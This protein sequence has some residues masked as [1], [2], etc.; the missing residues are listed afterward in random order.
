MKEKHNARTPLYEQVV[1][2][3]QDQILTGRYKKGDLLPSET[4]MIESMNVSRITIRK[5]L[6]ILAETGLVE[7]TKGRGSEVIFDMEDMLSHDKP[8]EE[9]IKYETICMES[10]QVRCMLEPEIARLAAECATEDQ[11]SNLRECQNRFNEKGMMND[12]HRKL[13]LIVGNQELTE[14][15]EQ[16]I[17]NEETKMPRGILA[18]ERQES[19]RRKLRAQHQR[20]FQA[21]EERN[22][23]FAYFYM[24]EHSMFVR[25]MYEE[26]FEKMNQL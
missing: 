7:T 18:P 13:V 24:K 26:Y 4:Q 3:I 15:I 11:I 21:I 2:T 9:L 17:H 10:T 12:F 22:G 6:A 14:I 25:K 23:E 20:I 16:L 8:S 5:A 1:K 19:I